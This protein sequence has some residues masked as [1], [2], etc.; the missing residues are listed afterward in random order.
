[1][2]ALRK[3][4]SYIDKIRQ[5]INIHKNFNKVFALRIGVGVWAVGDG[6]RA[7]KNLSLTSYAGVY[8]FNA[9]CIASVRLRASSKVRPMTTVPV[10]S[11]SQSGR[12]SFRM[13]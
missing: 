9:L 12:C 10:R 13:T 11:G 6:L 3:Q 8:C 7:R 4:E 5:H 2:Q 1:M